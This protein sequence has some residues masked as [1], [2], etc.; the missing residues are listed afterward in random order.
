[1][2]IGEVILNDCE[3]PEENRLG[4][5]GAGS[6][7]FNSEMEWERSCLFAT[8]LGAMERILEEC[9][10]YA[11]VRQQSG[12][13]IG[14]Y[15]SISHKLSDMKVRIDLSRLVIYNVAW[16]KSQGKRAPLESAI[17]KLFVSESYVQNC[18]DALQIHGAYG[19][20]AEYDF[21]R[22]LRDALAGKIYSGTSEIQRNII[23]SFLGL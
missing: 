9:V 20:S 21:E 23:A 1:M 12:K 15:Q 5:E 4:R 17:A 8:H 13:P 6:A 22:N 19:Y 18:S 2:H 10:K 14:K 7:I 3:V 11:N 16:L